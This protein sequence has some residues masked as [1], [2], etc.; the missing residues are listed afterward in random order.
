LFLCCLRTSTFLFLCC[1]VF[2]FGWFFKNLYCYSFF[3]L[4]D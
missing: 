1:C 2:G 4:W 3:I